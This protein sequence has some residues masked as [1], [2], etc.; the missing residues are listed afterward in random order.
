M[1]PES[2]FDYLLSVEKQFA[3]SMSQLPQQHPIPQNLDW[4]GVIFL[5]GDHVLLTPLGEVVGILP[6]S[7]L[8]S[9]PGVKPWLRGMGTYRNLLFP[10][11]DLGGFLNQSLTNITKDARILLTQYKEEYFGLLVD[12]V[13]GLQ[14]IA[15]P[16]IEKIKEHNLPAE[17]EP[18]IAGAYSTV[19]LQLPI[20]SCQAIIQHPR[21]K[22]VIV[23]EE[24]ALEE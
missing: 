2:A 4:V 7:F 11:T 10:V 5:S 15:K 17:Y 16:E 14:R 9:V 21:F 24:E 18:F 12:R 19:Q 1:Q 22:D 8:A 3:Q 23:K 6:V 20:I 13:L